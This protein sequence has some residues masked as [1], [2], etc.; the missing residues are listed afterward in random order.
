MAS[1]KLAL[2]AVQNSLGSADESVGQNPTLEDLCALRDGQ[3][4]ATRRAQLLAF[5][6]ADEQV[7]QQ[8]L[9]VLE[10]NPLN[11]GHHAEQIAEEA[12][13]SGWR[14]R[15]GSLFA[16]RAPWAMGSAFAAVFALGVMVQS[17]Q[18]SSVQNPELDR[19]YSD[20][21]SAWSASPDSLPALAT[22][23]SGLM[24]NA[25]AAKQALFVG[26][27]QGLQELGSEF[28]SSWLP[29]LE[30]DPD[31]VAEIDPELFASLHSSGKLTTLSHFKCQLDGQPEFFTS[32][33]AVLDELQASLLA[34]PG[35]LALTLAESIAVEG[36]AR[37][38]VC[39]FARQVLAQLHSK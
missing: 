17:P 19:L 26:A 32:T 3:L 22:R 18:L 16:G 29:A 9:Q 31:T 6:A 21:G 14:E 2:A 37:E 12:V 30:V 27:E 1:V 4:D 13:A 20:Y 24:K 34:Q 7:Y 8:W 36:P 25:S 15:L 39:G 28:P 23:N 5:L 11:V 33:S 38:K 35:E 10:A